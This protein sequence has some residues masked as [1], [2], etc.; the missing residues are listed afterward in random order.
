M[1]V[2][3]LLQGII[4]SLLLCEQFLHFSI[5]KADEKILRNVSKVFSTA[6]EHYEEKKVLQMLLKKG[7]ISIFRIT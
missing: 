1:K 2:L 4:P 7:G 5:A 6:S 3:E